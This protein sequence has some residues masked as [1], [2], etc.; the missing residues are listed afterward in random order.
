MKQWPVAG[1]Q[2]IRSEIHYFIVISDQ[3][4]VADDRWPVASSAL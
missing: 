3:W 4:P 2:L 1:G